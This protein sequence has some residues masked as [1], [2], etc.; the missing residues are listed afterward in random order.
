MVQHFP[1]RYRTWGSIL[2]TYKKIITEVVNDL[3]NY[4]GNKQGSQSVK[5][6]LTPLYSVVSQQPLSAD[7]LAL[8]CT[9]AVLMAAP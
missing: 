7:S 3:I 2:S 8:K 6:V 1:S 5:T 9:L 4:G